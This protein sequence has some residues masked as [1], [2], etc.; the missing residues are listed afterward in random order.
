MLFAPSRYL[1]QMVR[2]SKNLIVW[3]L[4]TS[5]RVL[6][7]S[8]YLRQYSDFGYNEQR[9]WPMVTGLLSGLGLAVVKLGRNSKYGATDFKRNLAESYIFKNLNCNTSIFR[10]RTRLRNKCSRRTNT[11]ELNMFIFHIGMIIGI[12]IFIEC[13]YLTLRLEFA[14]LQRVDLFEVNNIYI[15]NAIQSIQND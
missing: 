5:S 1:Y 8:S 3:V 10:S 11:F 9:D 4:G 14:R 15:S 12:C 6:F 13:Q 2:A 7:R